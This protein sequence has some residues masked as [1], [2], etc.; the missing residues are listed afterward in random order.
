[1]TV[2]TA[3]EMNPATDTLMYGDELR[4]GMWVMQ[5][6]EALRCD[7]NGSEDRQI[8]M[9]RFCR[10]T[11][12]RTADHGHGP[13]ATFIGKWVDGYQKAL[14]AR[15]DSAW[16]VRREDAPSAEAELGTIATEENQ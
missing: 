13:V 7:P 6:N 2:I 1:M 8:R 9:N 3:Y 12:L 15:H 10:V 14:Y 4:E 11:R 5:E 16:I